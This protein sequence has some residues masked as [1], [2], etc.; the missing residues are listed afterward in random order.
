M[1]SVTPNLFVKNMK[2]T[3][4]FYKDLGFQLSMTVPE[5]GDDFIWTMMNC[6]NAVLMFQTIG[7]LDK[8][9]LPEIKRKTG[10]S[11]LLYFKTKGIKTF[12]DSIKE[13]V[14]LLKGVKKTFYGATEFT[15]IDCDGY[16]LTFAEDEE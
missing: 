16:V 5:E 2:K 4:A 9:D 15:I 8:G 7:S 10:G 6:G 11:F 14:K 3:V 12:F 1:E 13:K